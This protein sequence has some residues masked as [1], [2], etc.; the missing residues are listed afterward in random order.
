VPRHEGDEHWYEFSGD[1]SL[2]KLFGGMEPISNSMA[3]PICASWN[4]LSGWLKQVEGLRRV[5]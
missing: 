1:G 3:S 5:A 2:T 4:Q